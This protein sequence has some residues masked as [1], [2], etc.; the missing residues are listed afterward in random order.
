MK[1][2][3][4]SLKNLALLVGDRLRRRGVEAVLTGGACVSIYTR[5]RY[6]SYDLDFVLLA[7][8]DKKAAG[9]ALAELGFRRE[10]RHFR[11]PDTPFL[12]EF[13]VPPLSIGAAPVQEISTISAGRRVLRLLSPTDCVK[14]RLAAYYFW[15]DRQSLEQALLVALRHPID[16]KDV[17]TWSASEGMTERLAVFLRQFREKKK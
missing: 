15:N 9:D 8:E 6:Q 13:L 5:N 14:D 2:R 10:G 3:N 17:K 11:H 4:I 7:A 12:V 1:L 16:M